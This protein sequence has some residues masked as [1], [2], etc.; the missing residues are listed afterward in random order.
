MDSYLSIAGPSYGEI[1]KI[2]GSRFLSA[3]F[4]LSAV[5]D[6]EKALDTVRK[7]HQGATH[8]CYAWRIVVQGQKSSDDGEPAGTAGKPIASQIAGHELWD[9]LVVVVRYYGGTK[10]GT[11][12]LIRAYAAAA[13]AVLTDA[14]FVERRKMAT[15]RVTHAYEHASAI[16]A[17][18]A[19]YQIEIVARRYDVTTYLEL[20]VPEVKLRLVIAD[21]R[22]ATSG[23]AIIESLS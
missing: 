2:K 8:H 3:A 10:L 19:R 23:Q 6:A 4:P 5:S 1:E 22:D 21:L 17:V 14:V 9:V 16:A 11:G 18:I 12:G 7:A 20:S 13:K 15:L